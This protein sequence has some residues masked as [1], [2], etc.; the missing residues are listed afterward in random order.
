MSF[1][2]PKPAFNQRKPDTSEEFETL[3][4]KYQ[5]RRSM[6]SSCI[7]Q[8]SQTVQ[9]QTSDDRILWW[10]RRRVRNIVLDRGGAVDES[11]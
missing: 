2:L 4:V 5:R 6:P 10:R 3:Q 9:W 7:L 8:C 11:T 1:N